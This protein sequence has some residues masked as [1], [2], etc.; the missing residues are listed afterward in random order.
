MYFTQEERL[1]G[2]SDCVA[3]GLT[4]G[5]SF[6]LFVRRTLSRRGYKRGK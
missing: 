6:L 2:I 4:E 3:C 1:F 5:L